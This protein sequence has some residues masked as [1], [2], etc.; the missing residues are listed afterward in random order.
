VELYENLCSLCRH[1]HPDTHPPTCDAFLAGIPLEIRL[2][3]VDHRRRYD[4]DGG[5]V[6][7]SK[8]DTPQTR[9][10]LAK[11]K[12]RRPRR[13]T[14]NELDRQVMAVWHLLPFKG[15]RQQAQFLRRVR[16]VETFEELPHA[17]QQLIGAGEA[18]LGDED[19]ASHDTGA[20]VEVRK[21]KT[22]RKRR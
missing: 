10:R 15:R 12:I 17:A 1:H 18:R 7:A 6:F 13:T 20:E 8:D 19:K 5:I 16:E 14:P 4:G 11:V 2:M 22:N 3:R 21:Y 9:K